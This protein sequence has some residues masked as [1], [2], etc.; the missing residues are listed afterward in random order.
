MHKYPAFNN[1]ILQ[2]IFI[3]DITKTFFNVIKENS[4]YKLSE[5]TI[6]TSDIDLMDKGILKWK[7]TRLV[8]ETIAVVVASTVNG[9]YCII[10]W[11]TMY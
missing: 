10:S 6:A 11:Y 8:S 2:S 3:F 7:I 1:Y 5:D 4:F 9:R